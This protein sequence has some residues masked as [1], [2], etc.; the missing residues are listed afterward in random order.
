MTAGDR[1]GARP[2]EIDFYLM[3]WIFD[4]FEVASLIHK[5]LYLQIFELHCH[6]GYFKYGD[7][8]TLNKWLATLL[9]RR[10]L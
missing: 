9:L 10:D 6:G 5:V 4:K 8:N 2:P 3:Q 7:I 1:C